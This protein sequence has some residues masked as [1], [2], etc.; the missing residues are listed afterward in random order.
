M[1]YLFKELVNDKTDKYNIKNISQLYNIYSVSVYDKIK[2][3]N[4]YNVND[5][6][7]LIN[8]TSQ[9]ITSKFNNNNDKSNLMTQII[10]LQTII[11]SKI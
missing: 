2:K 11:K 4:N 3:Y 9:F 1:I 10:K 6:E 7:K 8:N 5:L